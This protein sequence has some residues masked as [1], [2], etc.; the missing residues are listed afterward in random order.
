MPRVKKLYYLN[1][2]IN[3]L[4]LRSQQVLIVAHCQIIRHGLGLASAAHHH[5]SFC[6]GMEASVHAV[7]KSNRKRARPEPAQTPR[8]KRARPQP[9]QT[10][11]PKLARPETAQG[12][13][14]A[15]QPLAACEAKPIVDEIK[16]KVKGKKFYPGSH[17]EPRT[18]H[19]STPR[20]PRDR[21]EQL[22]GFGAD[23]KP[24]VREF[25]GEQSESKN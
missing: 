4:K 20:F 15:A 21:A 7:P 25:K 11:Q 23:G 8:P 3:I 6:I 24:A 1:F 16:A 9:A 14:E 5:A 19:F 13:A 18:V 17:T 2:L 10:P 22:L 12:A